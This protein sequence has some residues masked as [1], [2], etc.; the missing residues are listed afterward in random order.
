MKLQI[1]LFIFSALML[2]FIIQ[3]QSIDT[4]SEWRVNSG[5]LDLMTIHY[6]FYKD[7]IEGDTTIN[8]IQYL[9]IY[10]SG[11]GYFDY[12]PNPCYYYFNHLLHGF[13]R[14][15]NNKWFTCNGDQDLLLFDFNLAVNDT[16]HSAYTF[17]M[18]P[19]IIT[20]IDSVI[21]DSAYKKRFHLNIADNGAE[22][23]IESIGATTGL[24]ED[25]VFF[26]W[27]SELVCFAKNGISLW[28]SQ[29]EDCDLNVTVRENKN[30]SQACIVY[31]NPTSKS[32]TI[33]LINFTGF[34]YHIE[35]T[36]IKGVR[37]FAAQTR[38][39]KIVIDIEN[40]S[41][42]IYF[43]HLKSD[44]SNYVVKFCKN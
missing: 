15:E 21:I 19:I 28:G 35:I 10:K 14:E 26:E 6:E 41:N 24:F 33:D 31:P 20:Q 1:G 25:M 34:L 2:S 13:L 18:G 3:A 12:Y 9:K 36:D 32:V 37:L 30:T 43:V 7:Y 16:V 23:I 29:T 17:S 44:A 5:Y 4:S 39:C 42:G 11:Y 38:E 22:Y 40:Y 27:S 8:T